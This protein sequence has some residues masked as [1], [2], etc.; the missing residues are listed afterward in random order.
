MTT[1]PKNC[2]SLTIQTP[3][4]LTICP[5]ILA[6][7]GLPLDMSKNYFFLRQAN[8]FLM[9]WSP[10]GKVGHSIRNI[11]DFSGVPIY[12]TLQIRCQRMTASDQRPYT[13]CHSQSKKNGLVQ[14]LGQ[15]W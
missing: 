11:F 6:S 10:F 4:P 8:L 15:I 5:E 1:R 2:T 9:E 14:I 13:V 7:S 12:L 3:S